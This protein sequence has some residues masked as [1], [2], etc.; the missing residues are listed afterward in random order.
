MK[1]NVAH[2]GG[3]ILTIAI[4]VPCISHANQ[5]VY[6]LDQAQ[7]FNQKTKG[8]FLIQAASFSIGAN[9]EK[10]RKELQAKTTYP[11][12]IIRKNH[13]YT[14]VIGPIQ[15]TGAL[16]QAATYLLSK[17][18]THKA[19]GSNHEKTAVGVSTYSKS[20]A[21]NS[22]AH[23]FLSFNIG[24]QFQASKKTMYINNG[25]DYPPPFNQD[26]Y[27]SNKTAHASMI[28]ISGGYRWQ[29]DQNWLPAYSLGLLYQHNFVGR[30]GGEIIQYSDPVFTNYNYQSNLSSNL[31]LAT[32]KVNIYTINKFSPYLTASLGGAFNHTSYNETALPGVTPRISPD[33]T[34]NKS[35]FAYNAG[36]GL[37]YIASQNFIINIGYL[38]QNVGNIAGRGQGTW[39]HT[40]LDFGTY[41]TND[42]V[43][44]ATYLFG[45]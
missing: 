21:I 7:H 6:G 10:Y 45:K 24:E 13:F 34:G 14:V 11:V 9:A 16:R 1:Q 18:K 43:V 31:L 30:P 17:S 44:G 41:S 37:D 32:A 29:R 40:S 8:N 15:S 36:A 5:L 39:S 4:Y 35:Q 42:V 3:I 2:L 27:T 12:N 25:S 33:F 20:L 22:E 19:S 28:N 38:Y 26:T 23:W